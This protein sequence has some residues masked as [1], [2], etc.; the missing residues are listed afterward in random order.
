MPSVKA[1]VV[2]LRSAREEDSRLLWI[3][4]NEPRT[5]EASFRTEPIA[6]EEHERWFLSKLTD[7]ALKIFLVLDGQ[8][9]AVGYV[10][11]Q[12]EGA[13]A[14][15]SVSVDLNARGRGY[16]SAAVRE[17]VKELFSST[18]V[19]RIVALIKDGNVSSVKTFEHAG[20]VPQGRKMVF[21]TDTLEMVCTRG[22]G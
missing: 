2:K 22:A 15:I 4:R 16:G 1:P 6:Y 19:Q 12:L 11:F 14:K 20:F 17:G 18:A 21:H 3:W 7:P 10:R 9:Q 13:Q 5:R 8:G